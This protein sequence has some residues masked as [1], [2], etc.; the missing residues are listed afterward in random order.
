MKPNYIVIPLITLAV[1]V[2]GSWLTSQSVSTWYKSLKLPGIAPPGSFIGA[3]WT[4]I[5]ILATVSALI[6]WNSSA[7]NTTIAVIFLINA[8][9]NVFWSYL[10]FYKRMLLAPIIE[11][12]ILEITVVVLMVLLWKVSKLAGALLIPYAV[13]VAFATYLAGQIY[14]LNK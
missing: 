12:I 7:P 5:Y 1:A 9:L 2:T 14:A 11:M 13:W 3:V 6:F 4:I 8:F 10:F